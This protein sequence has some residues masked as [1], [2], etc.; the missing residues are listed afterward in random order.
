MQLHLDIL[1]YT[2]LFIP[3]NK[4]CLLRWGL[5]SS[6]GLVMYV[7]KGFGE[8]LHITCR[9][10]WDFAEI[11]I[12]ISTA[13]SHATLQLINSECDQ[14]RFAGLSSTCRSTPLLPIG[15]HWNW[16]MR[17]VVEENVYSDMF[18]CVTDGLWHCNPIKTLLL[19]AWN[20]QIQHAIKT[21]WLKRSTKRPQK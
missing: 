14:V 19:P 1:T 13:T 12:S 16:V 17:S 11:S 4:I 20:A 15:K 10:D 9:L 18:L 3:I 5:K 21:Q 7:C 8:Y 2:Q 6:F